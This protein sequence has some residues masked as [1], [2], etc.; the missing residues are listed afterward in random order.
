MG[1]HEI[2]SFFSVLHAITMVSRFTVLGSGSDEFSIRNASFDTSRILTW[3]GVFEL[4][5]H[6]PHQTTVSAILDTLLLLW[7]SFVLRYTSIP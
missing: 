5:Q 7:G 4:V 3:V 6:A 1:P 2:N